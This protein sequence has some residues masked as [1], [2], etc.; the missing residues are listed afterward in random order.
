MIYTLLLDAYAENTLKMFGELDEVV[1][2]IVN[3]AMSEELFSFKDVTSCAPETYTRRRNIEITNEEYNTLIAT[4]GI[5]S[6]TYSLRRLVYWFIENEMYEIAGWKPKRPYVN[7]DKIN[8]NRHKTNALH[9]IQQLLK[10]STNKKLLQIIK[11]LQE[12]NYD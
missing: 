9:S 7:E 4:V 8:F 11:E 10:Y 2:D 6:A 5:K 3:L 1:N 12:I